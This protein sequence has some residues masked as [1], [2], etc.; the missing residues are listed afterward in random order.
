MKYFGWN[1][2]SNQYWIY[3]LPKQ[4]G[5]DYNKLEFKVP[6]TF[7]NEILNRKLVYDLDRLIEDNLLTD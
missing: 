6:E 5:L 7:A 3:P 2:D 4:V 1:Y